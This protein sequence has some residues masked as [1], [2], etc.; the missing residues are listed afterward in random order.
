[1]SD[2]KNTW[3]IV[4]FMSPT[5]HPHGAG[6]TVTQFLLKTLPDSIISGPFHSV[7]FSGAEHDEQEVGSESAG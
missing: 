7:P 6:L 3:G 4:R 5:F 2:E 1:M